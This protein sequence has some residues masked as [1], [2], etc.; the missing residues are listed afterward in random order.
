MKTIRASLIAQLVKNP[1]AMQEMPVQ[2]LGWEGSLE[3]GMATHSSILAWRIPWT[4][5]PGGLL[6]MGSQRV[7]HD[8][9]TQH[10]T[11]EEYT[12][13]CWDQLELSL[14]FKQEISFLPSP[15]DRSLARDAALNEL[16][17]GINSQSNIWAFH[18]FLRKKTVVIVLWDVFLLEPNC[19]WCR[20]LLGQGL[21]VPGRKK[22]ILCSADLS[23][24]HGQWWEYSV[25]LEPGVTP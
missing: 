3:E 17:F 12:E 10:S 11:D 14:G 22:A 9:T 25:G 15:N 24:S 20:C 18:N 13:T 2:F 8:W 5:E 1:P 6:S 21:Q 16:F 7:R 19:I 23:P 4:E